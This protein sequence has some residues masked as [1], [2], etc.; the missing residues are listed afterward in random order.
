MIDRNVHLG[1]MESWIMVNERL[2]TF[3]R[4]LFWRQ[5][6]YSAVPFFMKMI[7]KKCMMFTLIYDMVTLTCPLSHKWTRVDAAS[8]L[9]IFA[10]MSRLFCYFAARCWCW[11]CSFNYKSMPTLYKPTS[12]LH[13]KNSFVLSLISFFYS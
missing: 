6:L 2:D 11:C 1:W 5:I 12:Q 7:N 4:Y 3:C 10:I 9:S 8:R 13:R